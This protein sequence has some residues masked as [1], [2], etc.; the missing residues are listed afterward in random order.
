[1][2]WNK[3]HLAIYTPEKLVVQETVDKLVA[4]ANNGSFCLEP[5]HVDFLANLVPGIFMYWIGSEE[6]LL[7]VNNGILVKKADQ[8]MISVRQ[9]VKG[10]SLEELENVVRKRF[11]MID[12]KERE[13]QLALEHLQADFV[14]R[15]VEFQ[16][17]R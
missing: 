10:N 13:T 11:K 14:K 16:K 17:Q 15:F 12:Q 8:V 2:S 5:R 3:M 9:A 7:A 4:E 1:M 6:H